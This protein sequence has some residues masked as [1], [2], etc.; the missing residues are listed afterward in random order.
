ML[1]STVMLYI[2]I[3]NNEYTPRRGVG[4]NF[5]KKEDKDNPGNHTGI[6]L[7]TT[8]GRT[9]CQILKDKMRI[10]MEK[11]G[12]IYERRASRV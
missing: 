11:E 7:L 3:W 5:L 8:V 10:M 12:I 2:W 6:A 9:F 1:T 4:V